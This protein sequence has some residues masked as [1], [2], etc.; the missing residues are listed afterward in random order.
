MISHGR[1]Y[2]VKSQNEKKT[3]TGGRDKSK[4]PVLRLYYWLTV[5][6]LSKRAKTLRKCSSDLK[7][8]FHKV[9]SYLVPSRGVIGTA[10]PMKVNLISKN[11]KK[12]FKIIG[13]ISA[14]LII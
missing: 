7:E 10:H 14:F 5:V 3:Y 8:H 1:I 13:Q 4:H 6:K 9:S 2:P 12:I 11:V